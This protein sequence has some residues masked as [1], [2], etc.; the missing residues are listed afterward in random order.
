MQQTKDGPANEGLRAFVAAVHGGWDVAAAE[1]AG[2]GRD[3]G[4]GSGTPLDRSATQAYTT[5]LRYKNSNV[6][7]AERSAGSGGNAEGSGSEENKKRAGNNNP[8]S[9]NEPAQTEQGKTNKA[10]VVKIRIEDAE[11]IVAMRSADVFSLPLTGRFQ[12]A[13]AEVDVHN[14]RIAAVGEFLFIT[15]TQDDY[16]KMWA[17]LVVEG[18][19][20]VLVL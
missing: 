4:S 17:G 1:C 8:L 12:K 15:C 3:T 6:N 19:E 20:A 7:K 14:T 9:T 13:I 10:V 2:A 18:L 11:T 5:I 16:Q